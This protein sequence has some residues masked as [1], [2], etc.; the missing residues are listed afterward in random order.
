MP[1]RV[2]HARF[3]PV[4]LKEFTMIGQSDIRGT[5]RTMRI[6]S[7]PRRSWG[8]LLLDLIPELVC[9]S[10]L[11][12]G[13]GLA[14][15]WH[16]SESNQSPADPQESAAAPADTD[17][18]T[19]DPIYDLA[20]MGDGRAAFCTVDRRMW[21]TDLNHPAAASS[22]SRFQQVMRVAASSQTGRVAVGM[23]D[24]TV[25]IQ[26]DRASEPVRLGQHQGFV[27]SMAMDAAGATVASS[28]AD[29]KVRVFDVERIKEVEVIDC[30]KDICRSLALTDDGR[31]LVFALEEKILV[32][33]CQSHTRQAT[34]ESSKSAGDLCSLAISSDNRYVAAGRFEGS[35]E[36]WDL[37]TGELV[38]VDA[39]REGPCL[40]IEFSTDGRSLF[41]GTISGRL[42]ER[43]ARTGERGYVLQ[44]HAGALR[45]IRM[46]DPSTFLT[47]GYDG[48]IRRWNSETGTEVVAH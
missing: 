28:A 34:L 6:A 44:A 48:Q 37:K 20:L 11:F 45:G 2:A 22:S 42:V 18:A 43:D 27:A 33:D 26:A 29:M 24:G 25:M 4:R 17:G 39:V 35:V 21:T 19:Q 12:V 1:D 23:Q 32:W 15:A 40:A 9:G 38:W 3:R 30:G 5:R 36:M 10:L 41:N 7:G 16:P 8:F 31:T 47:F 14:L 13:I 46:I